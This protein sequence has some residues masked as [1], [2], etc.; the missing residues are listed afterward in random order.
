MASRV[1]KVSLTYQSDPSRDVISIF[2]EVGNETIL[3]PIRQHT[4]TVLDSSAI[5]RPLPKMWVRDL[6]GKQKTPLTDGLYATE[7][8]YVVI[9]TTHILI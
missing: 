8:T 1:P 6:A 4:A 2:D 3:S 9:G 5:V 7:G